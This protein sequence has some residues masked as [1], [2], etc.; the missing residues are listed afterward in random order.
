MRSPQLLASL[1]ADW[2]TMLETFDESE[3][4]GW[5]EDFNRRATIRELAELRAEYVRAIGG[6]FDVRLSGRP[7]HGSNA[8]IDVV[9]AVVRQLSEIADEY[10]AEALIAP[11]RAGSHIISVVT[12]DQLELIEPGAAFADAMSTIVSL[13]E[14]VGSSEF[15]PHVLAVAADYSPG[16]L[17]AVKG[18]M[19]TLAERGANAEFTL[20]SPARTARVVITAA[21]ANNIHRTLDALNQDTVERILIGDLM[22][23]T[24]FAGRFEIQVPGEAEPYRGHVPKALRATA[25]GIPLGSPVTAVVE[26]ITIRLPSGD[27]RVRYRLRSVASR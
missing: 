24:E 9:T 15:E 25:R 7:V 26:E 11:S 8:E 27:H 2:T 18:L 23:F 20:T 22:G 19:G 16:T 13:G 6:A 5:G 21:M 17:R 3:D 12:P 14:R 10:G 1:I 4:L